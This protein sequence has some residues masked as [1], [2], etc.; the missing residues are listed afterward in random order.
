M[1]VWLQL[2]DV[3]RCSGEDVVDV[4]G[5]I[6]GGEIGAYGVVGVVADD[7]HGPAGVVAGP[8]WSG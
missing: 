1:R 6:M 2:G 8:G 5:K 4:A 7:S 3:G